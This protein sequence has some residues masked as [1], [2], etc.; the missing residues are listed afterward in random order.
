MTTKPR[1][2]EGG[3]EDV[4]WSLGISSQ[5]ARICKLQIQVDT[6]SQKQLLKENTEPLVLY[7]H[8]FMSN[9]VYV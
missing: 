2:L 1:W 3:T 4:E 9:H 6:L 7:A 5:P 8:T